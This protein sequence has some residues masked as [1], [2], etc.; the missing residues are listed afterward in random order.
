[1]NSKSKQTKRGFVKILGGHDGESCGLSGDVL[2]PSG[3][4]GEEQEREEKKENGV[5]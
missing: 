2:G 3:N 1:L 4:G 5:G